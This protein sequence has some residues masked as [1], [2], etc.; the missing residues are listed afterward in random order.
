MIPAEKIKKSDA[1]YKYSNP[2]KAQENAR[3]YLGDDVV[4]YKSDNKKKKYMVYDPY[5]EKFISFGGLNPPHEDY[6]KHEDDMRRLRYLRRATKINGD[7]YKN[8]YSANSLS[9]NILWN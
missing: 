4:L 7:W 6:L 2:R 8:P 5:E 9:I 3:K 1:L